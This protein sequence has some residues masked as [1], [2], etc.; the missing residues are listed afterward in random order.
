MST[1][2]SSKPP[3]IGIGFRVPISRF[4]E[5]LREKDIPV[6]YLVFPDEGHVIRKSENRVEFA[7]RLESFLAIHLGGRAGSEQWESAR[8]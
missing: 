5:K 1:W 7:R 2:P 4:V 3:L 6:E 8:S